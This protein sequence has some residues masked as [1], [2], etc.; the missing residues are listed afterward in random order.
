[1]KFYISDLPDTSIELIKK[2]IDVSYG[3][4]YT[5]EKLQSNGLLTIMTNCIDKPDVGFFILDDVC[6]AKVGGKSLAKSDSVH[7]YTNDADLNIFLISQFGEVGVSAQNIALD[8]EEDL[9]LNDSY[10]E[11]S[12]SVVEHSGSVSESGM[13]QRYIKEIDDLKEKLQKERD[14]NFKV[15]GKVTKA[16]EVLREFSEL[17]SAL[18]DYKKRISS[19]NHTKLQLEKTISDLKVRV[20]ESDGELEELRGVD[21]KYTSL[22]VEQEGLKQ[23][24]VESMKLKDWSE[25]EARNLEKENKTLTES[26]KEL[27]VKV[28]DRETLKVRVD[29]LTQ[30]LSDTTEKLNKLDGATG[31]VA[32]LNATLAENNSNIQRMQTALGVLQS[33]LSSSSKALISSKSTNERMILQVSDLQKDLD[34]KAAECVTLLTKCNDLTKSIEDMS[35][36]HVKNS[37]IIS[38]LRET[39][40]TEKALSS[41]LQIKVTGLESRVQDLNGMLTTK[42]SS[43]D[44]AEKKIV[45]LMSDNDILKS[46]IDVDYKGYNSDVTNLKT[47]VSS[48]TDELI[49]I[50]GVLAETK[51][52]LE[53]VSMENESTTKH[54]DDLLSKNVNLTSEL[55]SLKMEVAS[56]KS[57]Y[58]KLNSETSKIMKEGT[59]SSTKLQEAE[60]KIKVLRNENS[61]LKD[62]C[63]KLQYDL[64]AEQQSFSNIKMKLNETE[65]KLKDI[66]SLYEDVTSKKDTNENSS[67]DCNEVKEKDALIDKLKFRLE[68]YKEVLQ[69]YEERVESLNADITMLSKFQ[70]KDNTLD[71]Q[72]LQ[73]RLLSSK[74]LNKRLEE[75]VKVLTDQVESITVDESNSKNEILELE[76]KLSVLKQENDKL[77]EENQCSQ[78]EFVSTLSLKKKL[79]LADIEKKK[80]TKKIAE[81]ELKLQTLKAELD[82]N[83]D[84]D[85]TIQEMKQYLSEKEICLQEKQSI[86]DEMESNIFNIIGERASAKSKMNI[87]LPTSET[88]HSNIAIIGSVGAGSFSETA[89]V[90]HRLAENA[91]ENTIILDLTSES[92]LDSYLGIHVLHDSIGWLRGDSTIGKYLSDTKFKTVKLFTLVSTYLFEPYKL[93]V[94]WNS[95]LQELGSMNCK[96][97]LHIGSVDGTIGSILFNSLRKC[98]KSYLVLEGSPSSLRGAIINLKGYDNL[99]STTILCTKFITIGESINKLFKK[100]YSDYTVQILEKSNK[101]EIWR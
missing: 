40:D 83:N 33:R 77:R 2:Y 84:S 20:S 60:N 43:L 46:K 41:E 57:R 98:C 9:V 91:T 48:L 87:V 10:M 7:H 80:D 36:E 27:K 19:Y 17:Q 82:G 5:L 25:K 64:N 54:R 26:I 51:A 34:E 18:G 81:L 93:T 72:N 30:Q 99:K 29:T 50:K 68:N 101:I 32:K 56:E 16:D 76:G 69:E 22:F 66:C 52:E 44:E 35:G 85:S 97:I 24:L 1:M 13:F 70:D 78:E 71:I 37:N 67:V 59:E 100:L 12:M 89:N 28:A 31:V 47:K 90:L 38:E 62:K 73:G 88:A 14:E 45:T 86:I 11:K 21:K 95:R 96:I 79:E 23:K 39:L 3:N 49:A 74:E 55:N 75:Q 4:D 6:Y 42:Q 92:K 58:S 15:L 8:I 94:D 63:T 65:A 61:V 53:K